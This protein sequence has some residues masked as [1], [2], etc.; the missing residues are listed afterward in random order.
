MAEVGKPGKPELKTRIDMEKPGVQMTD[1][2]CYCEAIC[3]HAGKRSPARGGRHRGTRMR[4]LPPLFVAIRSTIPIDSL[5]IASSSTLHN[6]TT[7]WGPAMDGS[8]EREK[9]EP[10][11]AASIIVT[12]KA[13][14]AFWIRTQRNRAML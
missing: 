10:F 12:I 4:S 14:T 5:P 9:T 7:C 8:G 3:T 6:R 1:S 13:W 2:C 11:L